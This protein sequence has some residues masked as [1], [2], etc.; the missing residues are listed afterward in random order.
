MA[1]LARGGGAARRKRRPPLP[2][3]ATPYVLPFEALDRASLAVAGGKAA[4]LGEL[5]RAG[6]PVPP[7]FCVTTATYALVAQGAGLD[8]TLAELAATPA[9]DL[10]RLAEL[11]VAART[12]LLAAPV[13]DAVAEA[14]A[15]GYRALGGGEPVAVAVRSSA[16][17]EDL[18][19]AS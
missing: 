2:A 19:S 10:A 14:I 4:N 5:T 11:A 17:A 8:A 16:T 3:P 15:A 1:E 6:L 12:A 7:G 18:P 9:G 13:P